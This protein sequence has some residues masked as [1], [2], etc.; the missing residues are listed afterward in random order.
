MT[1]KMELY[2]KEHCKPEKVKSD[3][4]RLCWEREPTLPNPLVWVCR[5]CKHYPWPQDRR[6]R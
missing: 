2:R 3:D 5:T 6:Q 1:T 4:V